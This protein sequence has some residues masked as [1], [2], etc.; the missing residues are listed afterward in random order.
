MPSRAEVETSGYFNSVLRRVTIECWKR[1]SPASLATLLL[2][3]MYFLKMAGVR[4]LEMA[5]EL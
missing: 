1:L 2:P 5:E 3:K 4:Y